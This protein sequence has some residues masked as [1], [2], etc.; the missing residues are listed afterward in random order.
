MA[1][2][3][4]SAPTSTGID[5]RTLSVGSRGTRTFAHGLGASPDF[6]IPYVQATD[7]ATVVTSS[8]GLPFLGAAW[9]ATNVTVQNFGNVDAATVGIVSALVHSIAR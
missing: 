2:L 9:D 4:T 3:S 7:V 1:R 5:F 6:V 8:S